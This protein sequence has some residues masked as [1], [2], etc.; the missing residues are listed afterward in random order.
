[1]V[2]FYRIAAERFSN[3]FSAY[4]KKSTPF[5]LFCQISTSGR[6]PQF[7]INLAAQRVSLKLSPTKREV[8]LSL[9][10]EN[11]RLKLSITTKSAAA[12]RRPLE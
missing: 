7:F 2:D 1:M 5:G 10:S 3:T 4:E 9:L 6:H 12:V 8:T 11:L